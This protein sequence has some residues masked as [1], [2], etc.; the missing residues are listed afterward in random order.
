MNDPMTVAKERQLAWLLDETLGGRRP[1]APAAT[2]RT[3]PMHAPMPWLA[4]AVALFAVAAAV[5]V[6]VLRDHAPPATQPAQDGDAPPHECHGPDELARVPADVVR[7]HCFDFDDAACVELARFPQLEWLD[8]SGMDVDANGVSRPPRITDAG[9]RALA[10]LT[11][12]RWLCLAQCEAM[13]GDGLQELA[14]LPQLEHLD[15]THSGVQSP[16]I[17]LLPFLGNL[18]TLVLSH[19]LDFHGSALEGVANLP[20]LRR[21]ELQGCATIAAGDLLPLV[22]LTELRWL[23]LRDCQGRYRGQRAAAPDFEAPARFVDTDRDGIPDRRIVRPQ[24]VEDGIGVTDAVVAALTA[25]PLE[26]LLLGGCTSLTPAIGDKL[27]KLRTLRVLDLSNLPQLHDATLGKLPASLVQLSLR[28]SSQLRATALPALPNLRGLD[29]RGLSL[30]ATDLQ[31]VL[32]NRAIE[33]L[34]LGALVRDDMHVETLGPGAAAVLAAHA[35]LSRLRLSPCFWLSTQTLGRIA[36]LANLQ[37]LDVAGSADVGDEQVAVLAACRALHTLQLTRC[38][39]VTGTTLA[40]LAEV[41][42]RELDLYGTKCDPE[43][44]RTIAPKLWPGCVVTLPN[45]QRFRTP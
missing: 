4:A 14:V 39:R 38:P 24:P 18:R 15:L 10:K 30:S 1:A 20:R 26:A 11:K 37:E 13:R 40:S 34:S 35:N 44:V 25:L 17:E 28:D 8:L 16:A 41:P 3:Q 2:L 29:L 21:L 45:G 43:H 5:G 7:L 22:A 23:D 32:A 42:L 36:T 12:L 9:V 19:C 6:A 27:A 33:A 31:N